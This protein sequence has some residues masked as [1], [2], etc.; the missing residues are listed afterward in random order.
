MT[1]G[2]LFSRGPIAAFL[3]TVCQGALICQSHM[4]KL[5][6]LTV[7]DVDLLIEFRVGEMN[8]ILFLHLQ[9]IEGKFD[10]HIMNN[11]HTLHSCTQLQYEPKWCSYRLMVTCLC[12]KIMW[13]EVT[14]TYEGSRGPSP[15]LHQ[16]SFQE[17]CRFSWK[18]SS[19]SKLHFHYHV[20]LSLTDARNTHSSNGMWG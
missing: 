9:L 13:L 6:K 19:S 10:V 18:L 5:Y 7:Y 4:C 2:G 3:Q 16:A 20:E 11:P 1:N 17:R 12:N 8:H 14:S 15:N